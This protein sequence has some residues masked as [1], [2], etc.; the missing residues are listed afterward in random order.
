MKL[1]KIDFPV[2]T[3]DSLRH[4]LRRMAPL[5][6]GTAEG[7]IGPA[8]IASKL[9]GALSAENGPEVLDF[10]GCSVGTSPPAMQQIG[11]VLN[12]KSVIAGDCF[13]VIQ[14]SIPV[15]IGGKS[16]TKSSDVAGAATDEATK[17]QRRDLFTA[18]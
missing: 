8:D 10:R 1:A 14:R 2:G 18:C 17:K 12:A 11:A 13:A 9:Q 7:P 5:Q 6:F 3:L 4:S 15:S 16:V